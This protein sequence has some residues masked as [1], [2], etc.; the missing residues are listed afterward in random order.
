MTTLWAVN[1]L[2]HFRMSC[3]ASE[4]DP[5]ELVFGNEL[6][7]FLKVLPANKRPLAGEGWGGARLESHS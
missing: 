2:P 1:F 3:D 5:Q 4:Q 6:S 7:E